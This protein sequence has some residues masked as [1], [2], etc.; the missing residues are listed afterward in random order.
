M[1][2]KLWKGKTKFIQL[3]VTVST[4]LSKDS[5]VSFSSGYLIAATSSTAALTHAGVVRHAITAA[6]SDYATARTIEVEVPV[7]KNVQWK[8][9]TASLVAADVGLEVD[10]TDALTL[11]RGASS[12][13]VAMIH[14][15]VSATEAIAVL[16]LAGSY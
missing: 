6:D 11:N 12:V 16:K 10:L 1:S 7:E 9:T 2:I 15:V 13:D 8:C 3:P 14:G 4:V 5:I